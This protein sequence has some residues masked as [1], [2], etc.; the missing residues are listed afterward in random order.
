VSIIDGV[1]AATGAT[2]TAVL[3]VSN[4]DN[5]L[6][7]G[8][9]VMRL[10]LRTPYGTACVTGTTC[11]RFMEF[12]T[13]LGAGAD[14]GG[15]GVGSLRLSTAGTGITQ[16][17]G[18]AD[19]AEFMQL[20]SAASAGD[21]VSLNSSGQYQKAV[22]GQSLIG[23]I[24]ENPAF[25]GNANLEGT[26]NAYIVGFAGVVPTTVSTDNGTIDAGDLIT[27]S[28]TPGIGVKLTTSGYAVGQ[29]LQ[30]FSGPGVGTINVLVMPKYVDAA[31]ALQSYGGSQGGDSGYWSLATTSGIV[32]L[33]SSTYSLLASAAT[34]TNASTTNISATYASST[35]GFFGSLSVGSLSGIVKATAGALS[36][37]LANLASDVTGI[38]PIVNGGTGTSTTPTYGKLLIGNA[39]GSFD[40]VA[41]SS[42]GINS[43]IWGAITGNIADQT[44]LQNALAAKLNLSDWYSTTTSDIQEGSNLYFTSARAT[45]SFI[46]NLAATTSVSSITNLPNLSLPAT[47]L[48]G[49]GVPFYQFLSATTTDV[50]AQGSLNK[51][52]AS[53]LF[54]ADLAATTSVNS[55]TA[56]NN[57]SISNSQI[58]NFN[59]GVNTYVGASTTIPKTYTAN[60][61]TATQT[62]GN[63]STTNISATYASSTDLRAGS[64]TLGSF[65]GVLRAAAGAVTTGLINLA[66]DVTGILSVAN[67]GTGWAAIQSGAIPYGNGSGAL[68]T[69][70]AG[71]AGQVLALLNGVPTWTSTTTFSYPFQ[72]SAGNVTLAFGTTTA[73]TWSTLQQF[74]GNASS[75]ALSAL[76][77]LQVGRTAT[78]T[79]RGEANATST[80]AGG[81][82]ANAINVTSTTA[83]STF[84]NGIDISHGCF[85]VNGTCISA[86][87]GGGG[88]GT[89]INIQVF[90]SPGTTTYTPSAG[91]TV[92]YVV[93]TGGGGGGGA[94]NGPSADTTNETIGGGGGAGGTSIGIIDLTATS[95]VQVVVGQGGAGGTAGVATA[96]N[97]SG[98]S[99]SFIGT[100][101]SSTGGNGGGGAAVNATGCATN[102]AIGAAGTGG[103]SANGNINLDGG[104]GLSGSC[105][106]EAV[107]GGT[108]GSSYWGEGGAGAPDPAANGSSAG[109]SATTFGGGGGGAAS[110]DSSGT[111]ASGGNGA[112]GAVVVYEYGPFTGVMTVANGGT[113][114]TNI[115]AGTLL[116]GND[117]GAIATTTI[118]NGLSLAGGI[119]STSFGTTTANTFT[120]LQSFMAG[121]SSSALSVLDALQVGRNATTTIRGEANATSTFAGGVQAA[122]LNLTGS[123]ATS[124]ASS[125][126]NITSGCFAINGVCISGSGSSGILALG[127]GY[128]STTNTAITFSTTTL[129]FNGLTFGQTITASNGALTFT[130]TISGILGIAAGGTGTTTLPVGQLLYG[131]TNTYQSIGTSTVGTNASL[132]VSGS[133]GYLVGGSNST[134]SLNLGNANAWTAL[135]QFSNASSSIFSAYRAY[136]GGTATT[137]I[138]N[139]GNVVVGGTLTANNATS[140][141]QFAQNYTGTTAAFGGSG[142]TTID[143]N[144]NTAVAG[145]LNVTGKTTLGNASTTNIS[146]SYASSTQ[147]FFGSLSVGALTGVLRASAGAITTGAVNLASEVSGVL[148][149]A[150]GG[151]GW[152][153][154]QAGTL[155][156]GN[157]TGAV[158]TTSI[159][160][161]LQISGS[162]L[163][164]NLSNANIWTGLQTFTN[165]ST[166]I[167]SAYRAYFGGTATTTIDGAGN[168]V[169]GG[170]LTSTASDTI[171]AST[172]ATRFT[173]QNATSTN[174]TSTTL[175][176]SGSLTGAGLTTCSNGTNDK[177]L[178]NSGSGQFSCGVDQG[179]AGGGISSLGAAG[180]LQN[181]ASQ[182]FATSTD[183]NIGLTITSAAN[184]HTF[185]TIW[186]GILSVARGGTGWS[187][188]QANTLLTG[189]GTGAVATTSIG[190][191]LQISSNSLSLNLANNNIWTGLQQFQNASTTL[192]ETISQ[193]AR[194]I[195]STS[196]N[197]LVLK[198]SLTATAGLTLGST[199]T[200]QM[201]ALNTT[202]NRVTIGTG[203][204]SP[205]LFVVD[206]K[207]TTGDPA[208][209]NGATYFNSN[210]GLWRCYASGW[211][212]CGGQAAS[213][214]GAIQFAGTDGGFAGTSNLSWSIAN[215]SL[216]IQASSSSQTTDLLTIASSTG[217]AMFGVSSNGVIELAT[218]TDP[219]TPPSGQLD[220]YAKT[221]AGRVLPKWI[222]PA[223]LDTPFQAAL[224]SNNTVIWTPT[225][226][227]AGAWQGA[228]AG[229]GAGTFTSTLPTAG[230]LYSVQRRGKWATVVTTANQQVGQRNADMQFFRG[231][232]AGQGGFFFVAR[233]GLEG[234]TTNTRYFVGL[235]TG[236]TNILASQ[237]PSA[238]TNTIGLAIDSGDTQWSFIHNDNVGT[239]TKDALSGMPAL[240]SGQGYDLY[241]FARPNDT[242]VYYRIDNANTGAAIV[243]GSVNTDLPVNTTM[244]A[245]AA[246]AGNVANTAAGAAAIGLN[247]IYIETDR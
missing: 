95:S 6:S 66:S 141:N 118:G 210:D 94:A 151:T 28:S 227:T 5:T 221:V 92:A 192:L 158:A 187:N 97:G 76:D 238:N 17:S 58:S 206:N 170:S 194:T 234:W 176:I 235:T 243:E 24:S 23:V 85:S 184:V 152:A 111:G 38:L 159:G 10:N 41:T 69:T 204:S 215:N 182:T 104:T 160:S 203:G 83:S 84:G 131:G 171:L 223:G 119:L 29:A 224:F 130:P 172:T 71:T 183:A 149:V 174:A 173:V 148:S 117:T 242:V 218:T 246:V 186:N 13:G 124:T 79:I 63:A 188:I 99:Y 232:S 196:T 4:D 169:V 165:S 22:A 120:A 226:A 156:T 87:G 164:L 18:S 72:Y 47:Q 15:R 135:Q 82:Q 225:N 132:S 74:N 98:G 89:L 45:T 140:S 201:L 128:A 44:D 193:F 231:S 166:T 55:I 40:Y 112:K 34:L 64:F 122:Y 147:G 7:S 42:L 241:M 25:V 129:A 51:Y 216:T 143:T 202:D 33:A 31:V 2:G 198:T 146:A 116:T 3:A 103:T 68:A 101:A 39:A 191:S 62:F 114:W 212:T 208:G 20:Q 108:G 219:A 50:L 199:S 78:T 49:F 57:L 8:N 178:W 161:S 32:S 73:N 245:P 110:E 121:A 162:T 115:Q 247:R 123:S 67:G 157:G 107:I 197:A 70:S 136:F 244:M 88:S 96:N 214:T 100:Y 106:A 137:T 14:T 16:T 109:V 195:Q 35:R 142:T 19:F 102:G 144:G 127:S 213:S 217:T 153:N 240:A 233:F 56:L 30:S 81:V 189:N 36:T 163:S 113:G 65:T 26:P 185:T 53:S 145:T 126:F 211:R 77:A 48:S 207:N 90:S 125:G 1:T 209:I 181:G 220:I 12:F 54:A 52:Y 75:T 61:F 190:S 177:L 239:A 229:T 59:T 37:G 200:P 46:G 180:Q 222:G 86:A 43:G 205:T 154:I 80:F 105:A 228:A 138:D 150:S 9:N 27:A 11:P 237:N 21:L 60:T 139:A 179:G 91:A 167:I 93:V 175:F 134:I 168:V 236:T 230:N 155:V 133:L